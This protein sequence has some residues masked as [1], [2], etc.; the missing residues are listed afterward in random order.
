MNN[1]FDFVVKDVEKCIT[2]RKTGHVFDLSACA[3]GKI[4]INSGSVTPNFVD[5]EIRRAIELIS[6]D[7]NETKRHSAVI[8]IQFINISF[9]IFCPQVSH[10]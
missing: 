3:V 4:A 1:W 2:G 8:Y 7:K 6:T 5:F 10:L 9:E